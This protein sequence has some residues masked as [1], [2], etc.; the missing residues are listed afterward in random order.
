ML[1]SDLYIYRAISLLPSNQSLMP[2]SRQG[3]SPYEKDLAHDPINFS[4][5]V[6]E[7]RKLIVKQVLLSVFPVM[8]MLYGTRVQNA[9][10]QTGIATQPSS[11]FVG[12]DSI[13]SGIS[14]MAITATIQQVIPNHPPGTPAGTNLTVGTITRPIYVSV[15]PYLAPDIQKALV[16]GQRVQVTGK[17]QNV[18]GQS[19]LIA[20]Q[21]LL[22]GRHIAIRNDQGSLIRPRTQARIHSQSLQNGDLQ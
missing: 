20:R 21:L 10:A 8:L 14:D 22:G 6:S 1:C 13:K 11:Q 3:P 18:H 2:R 12:L 4:R 15:G 19:Y 7:E 5:N 16:A 17:I 9:V